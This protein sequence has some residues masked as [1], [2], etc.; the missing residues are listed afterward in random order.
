MLDVEQTKLSGVKILTPK[1]FTDDRGFFSETYNEK[2]FHDAGIKEVFVQDN[3]SLSASKGTV[4]GLHYQAPP[5][6]QAKL[7]RA[8]SGIVIDIAVDIRK[9]SPTFGHHVA[10]ELSAEN[11]KQ[12]YIPEGFLHGFATLTEDA[13]IVYKVNNFYSKDHDG[14]VLWNSEGL[15]IDW[16]LE[17]ADA[18]LSEK[19]TKADAWKNFD[20]P[21]EFKD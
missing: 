1:R 15:D 3:H 12:L 4:R 8:V 11:G 14:A 7:V 18:V 5:F 13:E 20:S 6:A 10:V 17:A 2:R 19:D 9:G 21:F 16:H